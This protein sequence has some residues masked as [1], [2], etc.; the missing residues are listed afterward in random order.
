MLAR[1]DIWEGPFWLKDPPIL[2]LL[3]SS[4]YLEN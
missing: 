2:E 4:K 3:F 1:A